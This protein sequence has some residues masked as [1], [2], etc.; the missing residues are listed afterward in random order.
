MSE[1]IYRKIN[2]NEL[3]INLFANFNRYQEVKKCWRKRKGKWILEDIAF[4]EQWDKKEY[5]FLVKCLKNTLSTGGTVIAAF[6]E[7]NLVGFASIEN[8]FFGASNDYLQLSSIHVSYESRGKGIGKVLFQM[9]VEE[10]R[11]LGAKKLYISAHSSEES[12][13]FYK[14][15]GCKEAEEYNEKLVEAE[16]CDC[17]LEY[18]LM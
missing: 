16:P 7:G 17:Q 14:A 5:E 1:I 4:T 13:A 6:K 9:I 12:Q 3:N 10:V 8:E 11:E 2:E 15:V 18:I